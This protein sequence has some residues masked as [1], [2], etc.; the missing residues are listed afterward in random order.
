MMGKMCRKK[1]KIIPQPD[2]CSYGLEDK[3]NTT[4]TAP[5]FRQCEKNKRK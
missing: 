5:I 3:S 2:T 4:T 1:K